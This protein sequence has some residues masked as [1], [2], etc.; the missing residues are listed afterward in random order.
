MR[1]LKN[2]S[3]FAAAA[4]TG[5]FLSSAAIA[6]PTN[7]AFTATGKT[8][9]YLI[10]TPGGPCPLAGMTTGSGTATYIGKILLTATDCVT[11]QPDGSFVFSNGKLVFTAVNGDTVTA[12]YGPGSFIALTPGTI[13]TINYASFVITGGTGVFSGASGRGE[14]HGTEDVATMP[15]TGE[16]QAIGVISLPNVQGNDRQA[17][18]K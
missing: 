10:P 7:V 14:L 15:A 13:Y 18:R 2:L 3:A 11:P 8:T 12:T 16:L 6:G 17:E 1:L 5:I 9:E 4:T